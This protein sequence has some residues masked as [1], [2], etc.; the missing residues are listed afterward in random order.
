MK[1]KEIDETFKKYND[2]INGME[3]FFLE[4]ENSNRNIDKDKATK[5]RY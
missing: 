2:L 4:F 1:E 3:K 5:K